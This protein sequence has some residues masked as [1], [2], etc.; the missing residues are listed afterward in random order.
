V[1]VSPS[2]NPVI[3]SAFSHSSRPDRPSG[4]EGAD[5]EADDDGLVLALGLILGLVLELGDC[6]AEGLT[7]GD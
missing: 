1:I 4:V 7:E 5:G 3:A 2:F 6:E